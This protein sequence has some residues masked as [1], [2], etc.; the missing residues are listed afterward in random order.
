M[1]M[2]RNFT[3]L[4]SELAEERRK[5]ME[6]QFR[7]LSSQLRVYERSL[8]QYS[9][10]EETAIHLLDQMNFLRAVFEDIRTKLI[11]YHNLP[12]DLSAGH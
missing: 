4:I 7:A 12:S 1:K 10:G 5:D 6:D 11:K 9:R 3:V 2:A 8:Q